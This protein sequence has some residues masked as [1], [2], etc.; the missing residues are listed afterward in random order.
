MA[1]NAYWHPEHFVCRACGRP[2]GGANFQIH[3]GA[4]Y[5][6]ECYRDRI[7]ER[8]AYCSRP[9]IG[10]YSV[11][12]WGTKF[13]QEHEYQYLHCTHC[14]RLVP[15]RDQEAGATTIRCALCR[16]RAIETAEQAK[17]IFREL[18]Q[19]VSGQGL[20]YHNLPLT[21]ELCNREKLARYAGG[22]A[23]A[24]SLGVTMITYTQDGCVTHHEVKGVAVLL[25]LPNVHFRGVVAHE[26]G[27]VWL[28]V[29]GILDLP[30]WAEEGFCELLS[31]RYYSQ[32]RTPEGN[33]YAQSTERNPDRIYG[34]G[35]RRV[36]AIA[37][38]MGWQHFLNVL[39]QT[40]R[41]PA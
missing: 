23:Q 40:K 26:L 10:L 39:Q 27:H 34:E 15:P 36:R 17:P 8:C 30:D 31:Y 38:R 12:Q 19:W 35:F 41:L 28:G 7:A 13:C 32:L 1:L 29:Q 18:I 22:R 24:H 2:I 3:E 9:L 20:H 21:L 33:H 37:D 11:D 25:G 4:P 6:E 16:S 14:G 5:H